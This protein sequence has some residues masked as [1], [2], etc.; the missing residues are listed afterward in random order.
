MSAMK[1]E[2]ENVSGKHC[3]VFKKRL[4]QFLVTG[5]IVDNKHN[6]PLLHQRRRHRLMEESPRK[7]LDLG[8]KAILEGK[9]R[10]SA[11]VT[12]KELARIRH[13]INGIIAY[14]K[15]IRM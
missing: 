11:K 8:E 7:V 6:C 3:K 9:V 10:K 2:R 14:V 15:N 1:A 4:E 12:S 5:R 13:V